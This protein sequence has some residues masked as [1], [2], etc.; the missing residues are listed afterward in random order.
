MAMGGAVS[1]G[2]DRWR[3]GEG[4]HGVSWL[5][6]WRISVGK[7]ALLQC[8]VAGLLIIDSRM[9]NDHQ[10]GLVCMMHMAMNRLYFRASICDS[11]QLSLSGTDSVHGPVL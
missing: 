2:I 9:C 7:N 8:M 10:S 11:M 4:R 5:G 6:G 3:L 1:V